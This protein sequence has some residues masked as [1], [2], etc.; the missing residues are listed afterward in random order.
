M[1]KKYINI[2]EF[3]NNNNNKTFSILYRFILYKKS[4]VTKSIWF[5]KFEVTSVKLSKI[6]TSCPNWDYWKLCIH[7]ST[8]WCYIFCNWFIEIF[9]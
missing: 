3:K 4:S 9:F 7:D 6:K 1:K 5:R 8:S 2:Q